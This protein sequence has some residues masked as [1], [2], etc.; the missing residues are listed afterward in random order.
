MKK[1][2]GTIVSDK[3]DK[4]VV[5]EVITLKKHPKYERRFKM[6]KRYKAHD[7]ENKYKGKVGEVVRIEETRPMSRDKRW[8]II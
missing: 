5:V 6:S 2:K 8:K 7:P 4:T 1:L 3:M